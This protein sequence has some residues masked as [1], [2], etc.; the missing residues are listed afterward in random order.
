MGYFWADGY[1]RI[2]YTNLII[3]RIP[4]TKFQD[5]AEKN[6]VLGYA[7]FHRSYVYYRLT[8]QFGD[9]PFIGMF[10]L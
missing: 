9:V 7:Y 10:L 1:Q 3:N 6:A 8:Q 4:Q 2:R 5:E